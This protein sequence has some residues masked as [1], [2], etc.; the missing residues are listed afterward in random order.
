MLVVSEDAPDDTLL[1]GLEK[2]ARKVKKACG[3]IPPTTGIIIGIRLSLMLWGLIG[4][5]ILL[6][7]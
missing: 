1:E 6:M 3:L 7:R 4:L 2:D 5:I